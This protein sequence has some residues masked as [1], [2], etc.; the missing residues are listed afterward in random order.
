MTNQNE[1]YLKS[2]AKELTHLPQKTEIEWVE[3]KH[4]NGDPEEIGEY[5][6]ALAN[7][8]ALH[9]KA[10]A[11]MLW[12]IDDSTHEIIGT[13][14][15]PR[16]KKI[17]NEE[18]ENWLLRQLEPKVD[19]YFH[20]LEVKN[21]SVALLEIDAAFRHP[22]RFKTQE[23]I[24]VGSYKKKLKDFP[25]KERR[26]WKLFDSEPFE[27]RI[28]V[29]KQS[30]ENTLALL[31]YSAYFELLGLPLPE[32]RKGILDAFVKEK[33]ILL[34]DAGSW[35]ITNL[36]AVLFAKDLS[37]FEGLKRKSVRVVQYNGDSR[38]ETLR[39]YEHEKGYASAYEEL[40]NYIDNLLPRNEEIG[41]A[42]RKNVSMFPEL[43]IRELVA[44]ALIHQ[45]FHLGGTGVMV[46]IFSNRL[47]ISNPGTPLVPADRFL[48]SPPIS[49]NEKLASFLRRVNVC[50]ERGS[51][52]DKV[53]FQ[54]ELFQLPP[55]LF[56]ITDQHTRCV[57]FAYKELSAMQKE[58]KV[59]ACYLHACLRFV[60]REAMTNTS[61]RDRFG[62]DEKNS[63][64]ASRM[65]KD[66]V[67]DGKIKLYDPKAARKYM[68]YLP[69]WA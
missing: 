4:N 34:N 43:A 15:F 24:R 62:I 45:D 32:S 3:Y 51:G 58:E 41:K 35:N 14:F 63:A 19:F 59:R 39:E 2:L 50:E 23:F 38:I 26:L 12:G 22:V 28:A 17:G 30:V 11:Y 47:E 68:R 49:R 37:K 57:L 33:L 56:E 48:D 8:A 54:T 21:Y 55:P 46:E 52:I 61:L 20:E 13:N 16:K 66:A 1:E 36:G 69:H 31:N 42:F 64:I 18:L 53:V 27:S 10:K 67:N 40:I 65:I 29:E 9:G 25:E 5:I 44:N 7:S 6:S 60:Q